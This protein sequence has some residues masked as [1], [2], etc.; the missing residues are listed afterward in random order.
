MSALQGLRVVELGGGVAAAYAG[1]L[2]ADMGADVVK[3]EEPGGDRTR[4]LGPFPEGRDDPER[5][6]LFLA[7]N[8]GKRSIAHDLRR[9]PGALRR[10]AGW[11]DV[12]VH[13]HRPDEMAERG[14]VW[15]TLHAQRPD[16]V[17]CSIT[18]FGLT[19]PYRDYHALELT[20]AHAGGWAWL[21][22]GASRR[23]EL[24]PLKAFGHHA[25]LQAGVAAV[26]AALAARRG[27][28]AGGQ[29]EHIDLSIQEYV[30]SYLDGN[31]VLY[32]YAGMVP[33]RL[34]RRLL[35]PWGIFACRDGLIFLVTIEE[36][37]WQR[38]V[39]LMGNPEWAQ[40]DLFQSAYSRAE[41]WDAIKPF[42]DDWIG[43]WKVEDLFHAAQKRRIC[44]SPVFDMEQLG[45]QEHLAA[46]GF[47]EE[48]EHPAAGRLRLLGPPFRLEAGAPRAPRPAPRLGQDDGFLASLPE[49]APAPP[50]RTS[51]QSRLPLDGVRVLDLSWV[52]AGPFCA[53]HL[54]HLGADVI[55]LESAVRT[56]AGRR[57]AIFPAG[58]RGGVNRSGYFNQ[59]GQGKRSVGLDLQH[60]EGRAIAEALVRKADVVV[61]NYA[62][63]VL[64]RLGL[65]YER[66]RELKPD[67]ILA[68]ISGFGHTGPLRQYMG[69]GPAITPLSGLSSVTGYRGGPPEEVGISYGD[70]TGGISAAA[71]VCAALVAR[72]ASGQGA[73]IDVSL[74]ESLAAMNVEGWMALQLE[75]APPE[76][77]GNRDPRCAPHGC[78]RCAGDDAWVTIG[79]ADD[80]M[81]RRLAGALGQPELATDPRF[82]TAKERKAHE[83]EL[84]EILGA[85]ARTRDR[86]DVTRTLQAAGV[87]SF[88]SL[89][90]KDLVEDPHLEARRFFERLEHPEVGARAHAGIPWRLALGPNGVR[91]PAPLLGQHTAEVLE[92]ILGY[93]AEKVA[94]LARDGAI[95]L[96]KRRP[97]PAG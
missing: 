30:A 24:P 3:L 54:A 58:M 52:W 4:R 60:P 38:L 1:R 74:W 40:I 41:N 33:S 59:W 5:S 51:G 35:Y 84:D 88:P 92:G 11:A 82:R 2:M 15:E 20:T 23:S 76:R 69:Y 44:M 72:E 13:D 81:F 53:L 64:E 32:T 19:G 34:G 29:G 6:G 37:Q 89:S 50:P 91:A 90:A 26:T 68:S 42:L 93:D 78:Y 87:A 83:D 95:Y 7:L 28:I 94:Q 10:L 57:L 48:V 39:E 25:E 14:L 47:F 43:E 61:E 31:L 97:E 62:T 56:D 45:T 36:D 17:L 27:A 75:G 9:D 55:R 8:G 70:P 22:P 21:S 96:Y 67:I 86:W 65:G 73:H 66:L 46:R 12:I 80:D 79:C 16:L 77:M 71:A 18:P 85:F 49:P 63:G